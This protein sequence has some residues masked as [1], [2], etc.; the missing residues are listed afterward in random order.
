MR[1]H[2]A[3]ALIELLADADYRRAF[4]DDFLNVSVA[5]QIRAN[6]K[7]RTWSQK[8]LAARAGMEHQSRISEM[9]NVNYGS[10]SISSLRRLAAAFDLAL[11]VRFE[12]FG[13]A[14]MHHHAFESN[15]VQPSFA[16]DALMHGEAE[17]LATCGEPTRE[18]EFG[19]SSSISTFQ[20]TSAPE[21]GGSVL[22]AKVIPEPLYG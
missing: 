22:G 5:A 15:L 12:S 8:E 7:S 6:R 1:S 16:Q 14:L 11:S 19:D 20:S 9:E 3:R 17:G 10:W 21:W 4:F 18:P 2:Q 13:T